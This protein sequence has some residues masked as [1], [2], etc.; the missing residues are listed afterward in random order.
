MC[1]YDKVIFCSFLYDRLLSR[2]IGATSFIT[3]AAQ[4]LPPTDVWCILY[5]SLKHFL[6]A[7]VAIINEQGLL[8]VMKP[9]VSRLI[10]QPIFAY[11]LTKT[12]VSAASEANS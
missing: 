9:P 4:H 3:S 12:T 2:G 6:K 8:T 7:D 11:L 1:G 10:H 5:P